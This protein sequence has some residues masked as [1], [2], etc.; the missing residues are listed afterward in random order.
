[1]IPGLK[2][3]RKINTWVG[4]GI[5]GKLA[6]LSGGM[7]EGNHLAQR[8]LSCVYICMCAGRVSDV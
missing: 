6:V 3:N 1:M 8:L 7:S 4:N 2:T 5:S